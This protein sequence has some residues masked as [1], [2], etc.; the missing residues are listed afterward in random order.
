[1]AS[2]ARIPWR[3]F[4]TMLP[5]VL[6]GNRFL[7]ALGMLLRKTPL[8]ERYFAMLQE[9]NLVRLKTAEEIERQEVF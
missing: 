6:E 8:F 2:L 4:G 9:N 7:I 1:M 5:S 3:A